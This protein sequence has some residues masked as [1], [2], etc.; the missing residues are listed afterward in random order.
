MLWN[1]E[2]VSRKKNKYYLHPAQG[3]G[4]ILVLNI[5]NRFYIINFRYSC[6]YYIIDFKIL[7]TNISKN[8]EIYSIKTKIMTS[9][10]CDIFI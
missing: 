7:Y 5:V 6:L 2:Y 3:A 1:R 10:I 9:F 8:Y 4:L